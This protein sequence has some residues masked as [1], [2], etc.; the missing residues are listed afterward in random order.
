MIN[1]YQN[2]MILC[3]PCSVPY[4]KTLNSGGF[5]RNEYNDECSNNTNALVTFTSMQ[6]L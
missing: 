5:S 2:L 4:E 6:Q 1:Q 3:I